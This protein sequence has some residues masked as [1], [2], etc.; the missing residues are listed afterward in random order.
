MTQ[1]GPLRW[2]TGHGWLVLAGGGDWR[3]HQT[4]AIDAA[5]LG[6]AI[7]DRPVAVLATAGGSTAE[8]E[9]L[10]DYYAD[11]GGPSGYIVPIFSVA[12]A[13]SAA[14]ARLLS[15][16]GL[17]Y[18]GD[19]PDVL[20]LVRAL[21]ASAALEA[22]TQAFEDGAAIVGVGAGAI[23]LGAYV[24]DHQTPTQ[25]EIG[26]GWLQGIIVE[27]HF[28]GTESAARLRA[29][30]SAHPD[31][32]GLGIPDGVALALGPDGRVETVGKGQVTVV[33]GG[34]QNGSAHRE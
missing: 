3:A 22:M 31:C 7:L 24:A 13:R 20:G 33:V 1:A 6:W 12:D 18:I 9:A 15:E 27:P 2:R 10:L 11:L 28:T 32:L 19:G 23:A 17:I 30:L 25:T 14:P 16:A 34:V 4:G 8:S 21:Q 5:A 29:M 26:W